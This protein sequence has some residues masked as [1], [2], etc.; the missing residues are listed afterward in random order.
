[1]GRKK[2]LTKREISIIPLIVPLIAAAIL[3]L[4]TI[5]AGILNSLGSN[6]DEKSLI[7]L[8]PLPKPYDLVYPGDS[9]SK[10]QS[11]FGSSRAHLSYLYGKPCFELFLKDGPFRCIRYFFCERED[12]PVIIRV[13]FV[14]RN[15]KSAF[16]MKQVALITFGREGLTISTSGSW[17]WENICG[18]KVLIRE[19]T[20]YS[21]Y[22][23]SKTPICS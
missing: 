22:E 20:I 17:S 2:L 6:V 12:D 14:L 21:T 23:V 11:V 19:Y 10:A 15:R 18:M 3:G 16:V 4:C 5:L 7:L 9:L 1:M 13:V 8:G